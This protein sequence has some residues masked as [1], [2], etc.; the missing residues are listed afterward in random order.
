M[1]EPYHRHPLLRLQVL[2]LSPIK[3][4][5]FVAAEVIAGFCFCKNAGIFV[6][7]LLGLVFLGQKGHGFVVVGGVDLDLDGINIIQ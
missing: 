5:S 2:V 4:D 7:G 6:E 3:G 1:A